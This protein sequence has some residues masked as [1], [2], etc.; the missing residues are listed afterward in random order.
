[1]KFHSRRQFIKINVSPLIGI[2]GAPLLEACS[3]RKSALEEEQVEAAIDPCQDLSELEQADLKIRE[4]LGYV[5][6]TP[7]P[8]EQCD[9]CNLW[10]PPAKEK[11]C[12]RCTLIKGPIYSTGYC[13]YWV[14][15]V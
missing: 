10:L 5:R 6:E 1:M 4:G 2:F 14:P 13:T 12:G 8:G 7:V 11:K 9:N 15:Q 3:T